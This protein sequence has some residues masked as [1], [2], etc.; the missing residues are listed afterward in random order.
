MLTQRRGTRALVL[1]ITVGLV[2]AACGG[3]E[4]AAPAGTAA[5]VAATAAPSPTRTPSTVVEPFDEAALVAAAK[6]EGELVVYWHSSR[7]TD[8]AKNFEAKY[9]IKVKATKVNTEEQSERVVREVDSKNVLVDAIG[10]E[11]GGLLLTKLLPEKYVTSYMPG[12]LASV[13]VENSRDPVI[14]QWQ[15]RIFG[16]NTEVY[17]QTCP[18]KNIWQLTEPKWKGKF[19]F[20]DP[21]VHSVQLAFFS[22]LITQPKILEQAYLDLYGQ[23][24]KTSEANAGWEFLKRLFKNDPVV[25]NSDDDV[26]EAVGA[27]GQKEPPI[28]LYV[29]AKHRDI[30]NKGLKVGVCAGLNPFEAYAYPI[31]A[32]IV[33]GAPH[34]NAAKLWIHWVLSEE[35]VSP[36][37]VK[38]MG[39]FSSNSKAPVHPDNQGTWA[40]WSKRAIF[41]DELTA[42]KLRQQLRDYWLV[43]KTR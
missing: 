6:K 22:T 19:I 2:A 18:I 1:S 32:L 41:F 37:T 4:P 35:G 8:A 10:Y 3:G 15:P 25:I 7:V 39:Y 38:D 12:D 24:L 9:G 13:I 31:Y 29:L 17:G 27:P 43:N 42:I 16:Y 28:G 40:D 14:Y 11:D 30:K 21:A 20:R 5:P 33:N 34:P 26:A 36:W 23:A